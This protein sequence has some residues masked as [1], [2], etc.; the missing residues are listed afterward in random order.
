MAKIILTKEE[1]LKKYGDI[2]AANQKPGWNS[3][4]K[5]ELVKYQI[6]IQSNPAVAFNLMAQNLIHHSWQIQWVPTYFWEKNISTLEHS[7]Q[8]GN[9]DAAEIMVDLEPSFNNEHSQQNSEASADLKQRINKLVEF[10]NSKP[11]SFFSEQTNVG[12]PLCCINAR[13]PPTSRAELF[14]LEEKYLFYGPSLENNTKLFLNSLTSPYSNDVFEKLATF[15]FFNEYLLNSLSQPFSIGYSIAVL[16]TGKE[17]KELRKLQD[18]LLVNILQRTRKR[19]SA[20][21][22][23]IWLLMRYESLSKV[24]K[25]ILNEVLKKSS[26]GEID[27][28]FVLEYIFNQSNVKLFKVGSRAK[29]ILDRPSLSSATEGTRELVIPFILSHTPQQ[30]IKLF[31]RL[32]LPLSLFTSTQRQEVFAKITSYLKKLKT[33]NVDVEYFVEKNYN[34]LSEF[35][36]EMIGQI[37]RLAISSKHFSIIS[38]LIRTKGSISNRQELNIAKTLIEE[39]LRRGDAS[40]MNELSK[41]IL[42]GHHTKKMLNILIYHLGWNS[43][44][45]AEVVYNLISAFHYREFNRYYNNSIKNKKR[46]PQ[47]LIDFIY[48]HISPKGIKDTNEQEKRYKLF[49]KLYPTLFLSARDNGF[50]KLSDLSKRKLYNVLINNRKFRNGIN[51]QRKLFEG[52]NKLSNIGI[53]ESV[54]TLISKEAT[55]NNQIT[56]KLNKLLERIRTVMKSNFFKSKRVEFKSYL[57]KSRDLNEALEQV[58]IAIRNIAKEELSALSKANINKLI[59]NDELLRKVLYLNNHYSREYHNIYMKGVARFVLGKHNGFKYKDLAE[60]LKNYGTTTNLTSTVTK[61]WIKTMNYIRIPQ[62]VN[63]ID[64][65]TI[66]SRIDAIKLSIK[67]R[68]K[69]DQKLDTV[70]KLLEHLEPILY[71]LKSRDIEERLKVTKQMKELLTNLKSE[72]QIDLARTLSAVIRD[73]ASA[74]SEKYQ[75]TDEFEFNKS[76]DIGQHWGTCQSWSSPDQLNKGLVATINDGTKKYVIL[77]DPTKKGVWLARGNIHL[78]LR[79]NEFVLVL[80]NNNY[81]NNTEQREL[82]REFA[83]NKAKYMKIPFVDST[84]KNTQDLT[85]FGKTPTFYSD[86]G[87]ARSRQQVI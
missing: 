17:M 34:Q 47:E 84:S 72:K 65:T 20:S 30:F 76:H 77:K 14:V 5:E 36:T 75:L 26:R 86:T 12:R 87:L 41:L 71:K 13:L 56:T 29:L 51:T 57:E 54:D 38:K 66:V 43:D 55:G 74:G 37:L 83:I 39:E 73:I 18:R 70:K 42:D 9:K 8:T 64:I 79:G 22:I 49:V 33:V 44:Q 58:E 23:L 48:T 46:T 50:T 25:D 11:K 62:S 63:S 60:L 35:P 24:K 68:S 40:A 67:A 7:V 53:L 2:V 85:V 21:V 81:A 31:S 59:E 1:V 32:N 3:R 27:M 61:K 28:N 15:K 6:L 4:S 16:R 52:L 80:D 45:A 82:I 78:A 19:N 69:S 10:I